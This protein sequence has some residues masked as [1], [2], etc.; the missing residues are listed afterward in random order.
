MR[1]RVR[2]ETDNT[3]QAC[4]AVQPTCAQNCRRLS[5]TR[6]DKRCWLAQKHEQPNGRAKSHQRLRA[7]IGDNLVKC[8]VEVEDV[9]VPALLL[10]NESKIPIHVGQRLAIDFEKRVE[11]LVVDGDAHRAVLVGDNYARRGPLSGI[12]PAQRRP[13]SASTG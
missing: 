13:F 7:K 8:G 1:N 5:Q 11:E 3:P 10:Y 12:D 2:V 4:H 6:R 9:K